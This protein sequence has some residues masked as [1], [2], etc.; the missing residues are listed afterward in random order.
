MAT[1]GVAM[2]IFYGPLDKEEQRKAGSD[3][4]KKQSGEGEIVCLK[5]TML[6][7]R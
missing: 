3:A 4:G 5:K 2:P 6:L 7:V 1:E